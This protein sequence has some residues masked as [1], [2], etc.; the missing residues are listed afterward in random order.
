MTVKQQ[1]MLKQ[2]HFY[3]TA[4]VQ[5]PLKTLLSLLL[6]HG[7]HRDYTTTITMLLPGNDSDTTDLTVDS[8]LSFTNIQQLNI[9][10]ILTLLRKLF[11]LS[12]DHVL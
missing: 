8:W 10:Y 11:R 1:P 12:S 2:L 3:F 7:S 6:L 5:M 9:I 4:I